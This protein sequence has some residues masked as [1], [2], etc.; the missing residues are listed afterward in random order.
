MS[1]NA[2][3]AYDALATGTERCVERYSVAQL[4]HNVSTIP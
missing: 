1:Q 2:V 4:P 3:S